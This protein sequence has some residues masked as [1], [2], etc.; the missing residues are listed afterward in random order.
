MV[1]S[2]IQIVRYGSFR[3]TVVVWFEDMSEYRDKCL[4]LIGRAS[5]ILG[6][7]TID[8]DGLSTLTNN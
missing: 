2:I 5:V 4:G 8:G 1:A 3:R 7:Y 6:R